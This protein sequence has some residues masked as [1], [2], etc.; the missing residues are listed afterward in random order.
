MYSKLPIELKSFVTQLVM[1]RLMD[2]LGVSNIAQLH[3]LLLDYFDN[4]VSIKR[5]IRS[6]F[7][8]K[9][10]NGQQ[11]A[12]K[13]KLVRLC[14][15]MPEANNI[16]NHKLF[17]LLATTKRLRFKWLLSTKS[18]IN[19]DIFLCHAAIDGPLSVWFEECKESSFFA[20]NQLVAF[21]TQKTLDNLTFFL[22]ARRGLFSCEAEALNKFLILRA[23]GNLKNEITAIK[24]IS[25]V[26]S[27]INFH[28]T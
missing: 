19:H 26:D 21:S 10:L 23:Y 2:H 16:I 24:H 20:F 6:G 7:W 15:V 25:F 11:F 22:L 8:Y 18:E 28:L 4:D 17:L 12:R 3:R 27:Q 5:E 13:E 9:K 14:K 1:S